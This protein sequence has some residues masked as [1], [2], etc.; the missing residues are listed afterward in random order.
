MWAKV[1]C[2][3]AAYEQWHRNLAEKRVMAEKALKVVGRWVHQCVARTTEVW[4]EYTV[5]EARKRNL[6]KQIVQRTHKRGLA[7][8]LGVWHSNVLS[9]L[10]ERAEEE[11]RQN[12][13][14]R[15][16]RKMLNQARAGA[17]ERW[18]TNVSDL[19]RQRKLMA[20]IVQR[21]Q[22]R[23]VVLALDLWHSNVVSA[24]QERAEEERRNAV[25]QRVVTRMLHVAV[26]ASFSRWFDNVRELRRQ[27]GIMERVAL[28]MKSAGMFAALQRWR[29]NFTEKKA[30]VAKS[31]KVVLRRKLQAVVRCLEAWRKLTA[32]EVR[33]RYLMGR[34]LARMFHRSLSFA[35]ELWQLAVEEKLQAR[36]ED[37]VQHLR[38]MVKMGSEL[39]D[40]DR[41]AQNA[42]EDLLSRREQEVVELQ[43]E[44]SQTKQLRKDLEE[45]MQVAQ[46]A[47]ERFNME[48]RLEAEAAHSYQQ[49]QAAQHQ[50]LLQTLRDNCAAAEKRGLELERSTRKAEGESAASKK[51]ELEMREKWRDA[52][53]QRDDCRRRML[54]L[55]AI[56]Q[57]QA[58]AIVARRDTQ[59]LADD[60][61][62]LFGLKEELQAS[63][64]SLKVQQ[65]FF[66]SDL[67]CNL[68]PRQSRARAPTSAQSQ[69]ASLSTV[70]PLP[71]SNGEEGDNITLR[72][73]SL[74]SKRMSI[75][76]TAKRRAA[77]LD[78][79]PV[80]KSPIFGFFGPSVASLQ[81]YLPIPHLDLPELPAATL[82]P[83]TF[84]AQS[85]EPCATMGSVASDAADAL[86]R[87]LIAAL[88]QP[89]Q[90]A[91]KTAQGKNPL[92]AAFSCS[93]PTKLRARNALSSPQVGGSSAGGGE[94]QSPEMPKAL[95]DPSSASSYACTSA[96][97][98]ST[99]SNMVAREDDSCSPL[100][101][102]PGTSA[103]DLS[104]EMSE[105]RDHIAKLTRNMGSPEGDHDGNDNTSL[106][107]SDDVYMLR[108][109]IAELVVA[110]SL[111]R[112]EA[113]LLRLQVAASPRIPPPT[114]PSF[115]L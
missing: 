7:F 90:K 85:K 34:I 36:R 109:Q 51:I 94:M 69:S 62:R 42:A 2:R 95:G 14:S 29:E 10:H 9:T 63:V 65:A 68:T 114:I 115:V 37:E 50:H 58:H 19:A 66:M 67:V 59:P 105:L 83:P 84:F 60:T 80:L 20:C 27:R 89:G 97:G 81:K 25:M 43:A 45:S 1:R 98:S 71:S 32:E 33:K 15:A 5:E 8:A 49:M 92:V 22:K 70:G 55:V 75:N 76:G 17:L 103:H 106:I 54:R 74:G 52:S 56:S 30:M 4:H 38:S 107:G 77:P 39:R 18:R 40:G 47:R 44:L 112:Q 48:K 88:C 46:A 61:P 100:H 64:E 6:M 78:A 13:V 73:H 31:T 12:I 35:M 41:S 57:R 28:Q 91:K 24:L 21:M 11:R 23:G 113:D 102:T 96:A 111:Q 86:E 110:R 93:P 101:A 72:E 87:A 104:Q 99:S 79:V 82:S 16:V 26:A 3:W 53:R 108:N